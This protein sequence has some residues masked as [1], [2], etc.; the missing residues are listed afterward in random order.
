MIEVSIGLPVRDKHKVFVYARYLGKILKD[1]HVKF[2][3]H[4][5]WRVNWT[6]HL[7][8][9]WSLIFLSAGLYQFL[10]HDRFLLAETV[11]DQSIL[12][13]KLVNKSDVSW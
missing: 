8:G 2:P 11:L 13:L 1:S 9:L 6:Y 10:G 4:S 3:L 12:W 5:S 7:P